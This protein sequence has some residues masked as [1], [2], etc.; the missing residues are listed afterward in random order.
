MCPLNKII[1]SWLI[2][3]IV[4]LTGCL[5]RWV[6]GYSAGLSSLQGGY[7]FFTRTPS[8]CQWIAFGTSSAIVF[9]F[10]TTYVTG[11]HYWIRVGCV[12]TTRDLG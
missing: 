7:S 10:R 9:F 5:F 3:S 1:I 4:W 2:F 6:K 12:G 8:K 11:G